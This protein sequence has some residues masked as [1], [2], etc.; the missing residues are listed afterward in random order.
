MEIFRGGCDSGGTV[1]RPLISGVG[2]STPAPPVRVV[3]VSLGKTLSLKLLTMFRP[4]P[5]M[6]ALCVCVCVCVCE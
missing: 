5:Y 1:G 3:K 6:A 4:E 2:G